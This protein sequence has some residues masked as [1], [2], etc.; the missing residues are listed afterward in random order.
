[1]VVIVLIGL[2]AGAVGVGVFGILK[3]G[4]TTIAQD[5]IKT[6]KVA[7]E[8]YYI[9]NS[10]YPETL[11]ELTVPNEKHSGEPYMDNIPQ[12]P[13]GQAYEYDPRGGSVKPT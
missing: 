7:L 3:K 9:E 2:L 12:D 1:M 5:Q 11:D 6:F 10:R 8:F 13:W 4:K